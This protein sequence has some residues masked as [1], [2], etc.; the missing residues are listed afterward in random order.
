MAKRIG[1]IRVPPLALAL[2]WALSTPLLFAQ[3]ALPPSAPAQAAN[4]AALVQRLAKLVSNWGPSMDSGGAAVHAVFYKRVA[5]P[6]GTMMEYTMHASG[7]A[8]GARLALVTWATN[9]RGPAS[10]LSGITVDQ[11]GIAVCAGLKDTCGTPT[12]PD[13]PVHLEL[14]AAPGEP[15]RYGL[16]AADGSARAF[17]EIVPFPIEGSDRGCTVDLLRVLPRAEVVLVRVQG[18][19][20]GA[21]FTL[22]SKSVDEVHQ[23][24]VAAD[25]EGAYQAVVEPGVK[26]KA[27]G[28]LQV[29]AKAAACQPKASIRWGAG[30]YHEH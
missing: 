13:D 20:A 3:G 28:T 29:V 16:V 1:G 25:S 22:W 8:P 21:K 4:L 9:Q 26:G 27:S 2:A 30:S 18:L 14:V 23:G 17:D 12:K 15:I 5:T 19:P 10:T 7:F 6:A 11:R 24:G